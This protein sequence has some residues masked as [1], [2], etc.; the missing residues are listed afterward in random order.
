MLREKIQKLCQ[1]KSITVKRLSF[2]I[3]VSE[4][5]IYRWFKDDSMELKYL[6]KIA[7]Y[8][9][10]DITYFFCSEESGDKLKEYSHRDLMF[11]RTMVEEPQLKD[12]YM[13]LL[14]E[15]SRRQQE[16]IKNLKGKIAQL[17]SDCQDDKT[18]QSG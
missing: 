15:T 5:T 12:K 17:E 8:F 16:E 13:Q 18:K 14:E 11:R 1:L 2:E 7:D 3:G 10:K 4:P 6:R 9:E